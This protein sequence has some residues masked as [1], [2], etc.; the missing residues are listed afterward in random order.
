VVVP[1]ASHLFEEAGTLAAAA[2]LAQDW[3]V[4]HFARVARAR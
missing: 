3:F 1:G 2:K 4:E